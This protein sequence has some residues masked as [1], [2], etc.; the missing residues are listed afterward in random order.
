MEGQVVIVTG[1]N[2]GIGRKLKKKKRPQQNELGKQHYCDWRLYC[3]GRKLP[4]KR[5]EN[6]KMDMDSY[7]IVTGA[8]TGIG[9]KC[10]CMCVYI[11][12]SMCIYIYI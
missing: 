9:R 5:R 1:A 3:I 8:N 2:T 11:Y 6:T 4:K 7:I 12:V 10:K